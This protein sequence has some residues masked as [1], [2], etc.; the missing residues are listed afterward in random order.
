GAARPPSGSAP[1]W[2]CRAWSASGSAGVLP[3][4]H[5][6][7]TSRRSRPCDRTAD[8]TRPGPSAEGTAAS[9][10]CD[11]KDRRWT[12]LWCWRGGERGGTYYR[13]MRRVVA[14]GRVR[15]AAGTTL[16]PVLHTD[17]WVTVWST[18]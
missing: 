17:S 18:I 9:S 15:E 6:R 7:R 3:A 10:A 4:L 5:R 13:S 2:T 8:A 14:A 12:W 1:R 16:V 11:R